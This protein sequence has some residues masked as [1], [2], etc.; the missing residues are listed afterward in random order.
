MALS[1]SF[2]EK[3]GPSIGD[4]M[5]GRVP[6]PE[7]K[8]AKKGEPTFGDYLHGRAPIPEQKRA[9]VVNID[10]YRNGPAAENANGRSQTGAYNLGQTAR[11]NDADAI[12]GAKNATAN[13][14]APPSM[15]KTGLMEGLMNSLT[16]LQGHRLS[17]SQPGMAS[18]L[19]ER[20]MEAVKNREYGQ[21]F[22]Y[23][24]A[25][26]I[27]QK[28]PWIGMALL[29]VASHKD[30]KK[31]ASDMAQA[32]PTQPAPAQAAAQTAAAPAPGTAA[33]P[34]PQERPGEFTWT[35]DANGSLIS[36]KPVRPT[37]RTMMKAST[38]QTGTGP[39]TEQKTDKR[40]AA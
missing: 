11:Q 13:A 3:I 16:L 33:G 30:A 5:H 32:S 26:A 37:L 25:A 14:P 12:A 29:L 20:L 38:I 9:N 10:D 34:V 35:R 28:H 15:T 19:T 4:Y 22:R 24:A 17:Q 18:P 36:S 23:G 40:K 27:S 31:A 8:Q 1:Y 39:G 2:G 6:M 21:M 7:E